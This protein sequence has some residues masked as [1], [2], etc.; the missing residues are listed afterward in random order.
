MNSSAWTYVVNFLFTSFSCCS[1]PMSL[2]RQERR[3]SSRERERECARAIS[4]KKR[5]RAIKKRRRA[6]KCI[7]QRV[8]AQFLFLPPSLSLSLSLCFSLSFPSASRRIVVLLFTIIIVIFLS[9][10]LSLSLSLLYF[11]FSHSLYRSRFLTRSFV[12]WVISRSVKNTD[13]RQSH[14][15]VYSNPLTSSIRQLVPIWKRAILAFQGVLYTC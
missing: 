10:S 11:Y 15:Y 4:K 2:L 3:R 7:D 14:L 1:R 9:V 8:I 5:K 6:R 12:H 13:D